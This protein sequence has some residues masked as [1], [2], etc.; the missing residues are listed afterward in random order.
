[1]SCRP[2]STNIGNY[3]KLP[4]T[5]INRNDTENWLHYIFQLAMCHVFFTSGLVVNNNYQEVTIRH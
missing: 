4:H 2:V 3:Q 1:M 5:T